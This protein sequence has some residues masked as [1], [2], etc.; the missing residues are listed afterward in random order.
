MIIARMCTVAAISLGLILCSCRPRSSETANVGRSPEESTDK[1][2]DAGK[3][4]CDTLARSGYPK[5][6]LLDI[7]PRLHKEGRPAQWKAQSMYLGNSCFR[8]RIGP[9]IYQDK[10]DEQPDFYSI[11]IEAEHVTMDK[12]FWLVY[13]QRDLTIDELPEHF[14]ERKI[15]EI[16]S[17][18]EKMR[19]V[20]FEIGKN[21]F[22]YRLPKLP[23]IIPPDQGKPSPPPEWVSK[24]ISA[25]RAVE[26][27]KPLALAWRP[28]SKLVDV[29]SNAFVG[30][31]TLGGATPPLPRRVPAI[32]MLT[33][34]QKLGFQIKEL[35][36]SEQTIPPL[37][38][39]LSW[40]VVYRE[41]GESRTF[42]VAADGTV[43]LDT[44]P[45]IANVGESL[46]RNLKVD[47]DEAVR[48]AHK[49]GATGRAGYF[50]LT[51]QTIN[52]SPVP[53]WTLPLRLPDGQFFVVRGDTGE[54]VSSSPT[55][56]GAPCREACCPLKLF[57][58][59]PVGK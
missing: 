54:I 53:T 58:C 30:E 4:D 47:S 52:G 39:V 45:L 17:F 35:D 22:E 1:S 25:I 13:F 43:A 9:S 2:N 32:A 51:M 50:R 33:E 42:Q 59:T 31:I 41:G 56:T 7:G 12:K 18:D 3:S 48:L 57:L 46:I 8:A 14:L 20:T 10:K 6:E 40:L 34:P 44:L 5:P 29:V 26:L 49:L 38:I 27:A 55:D 23:P 24:G 11:D 15:S 21:K 37:P 36:P 28:S 16:V 19:V